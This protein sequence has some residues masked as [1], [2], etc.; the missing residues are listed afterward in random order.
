M[1]DLDGR[2]GGMDM[3]SLLLA[4]QHGTSQCAMWP[5]LKSARLLN[6]SRAL[7][8][9]FTISFK[10]ALYSPRI[11]H[12]GGTTLEVPSGKVYAFE[13]AHRESSS[14]L[15][16]RTAVF[17][18]DGGRYRRADGEEID[19][20]LIPAPPS[21]MLASMRPD[22]S[23]LLFQAASPSLIS[24]P[25][26]SRTGSPK[27][28]FSA[29]YG[30][31]G[32]TE[33]DYRRDSSRE[34]AEVEE[35]T[36]LAA[37]S[38]ARARGK[39]TGL[40]G[41]IALAMLLIIVLL[42]SYSTLSPMLFSRGQRR[43]NFQRS[44]LL[45]STFFDLINDSTGPAAPHPILPRLTGARTQWSNLLSSQST[46]FASASRTYK[47]RYGLAPPPGFDKWFA[48]ATQGRNHTLVDEYDSLMQ[49]LQ[50]YRALTALELKRRTAELAQI[51]GISIVSIRSGKAQVHAKSG[52]WAPALAFQQMIEAFVRDLPD[53]DIAINEKPE[54][55]V[56]P[57]QQRTVLM[58]EYGL[59]EEAPVL[60]A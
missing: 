4:R 41:Q 57:R 56:L 34:D 37:L 26:V 22:H 12:N 58:E 33:P 16:R 2:T 39:G 8:L 25:P 31:F 43:S 54:G 53:M 36:R 32:S 44:S 38:A 60:S 40:L 52:R 13:S 28:E 50:P 17:G 30:G 35:Q 47:T 11:L 3:V 46:T 21:P 48:F 10:L 19:I 24:S 23:M 29:K 59:E 45:P 7:F 15:V 20:P 18:M 6:F 51:P 42:L 9:L 1:D 49:D 14:F 55:R 27:I 5:A